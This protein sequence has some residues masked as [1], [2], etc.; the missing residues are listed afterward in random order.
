MQEVAIIYLAEI[1]KQV[2][3]LKAE[4]DK[5]IHLEMDNNYFVETKSPAFMKMSTFLFK[6][7]FSHAF[8]A[9]IETSIAYWGFFIGTASLIA[10]YQLKNFKRTNSFKSNPTNKQRKTTQIC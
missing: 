8:L 2:K 7:T 1:L 5:D 4:I 10:Y 3:K 6:G 9:F